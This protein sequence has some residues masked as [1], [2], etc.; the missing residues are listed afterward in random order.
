MVF[1]LFRRS[2]PK[3]VAAAYTQI[4]AQARQPHFYSDLG[5]PDTLDGR[6]E[7]VSLHTILVL[8]R[9]RGEKG[10]NAAFAQDLFDFFFA[11]MDSSLREM[12]VGDTSVPKKIKKMAEAFYGRAAA[13]AAALAE[14]GRQP[15]VDMLSRNVYPDEPDPLAV[16]ALAAYVRSVAETLA[17]QPVAEIMDGAP[18]W[19]DA[20]LFTREGANR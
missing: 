9:L 10:R 15:L 12:G 18:A 20:T 2:L 13:L 6:F 3:Q 4:V 5:V 8:D 1:G 7:M 19:P 16:A 11:D 17:A 14:D